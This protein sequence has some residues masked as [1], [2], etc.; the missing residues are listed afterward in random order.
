M[1][2]IKTKLWILLGVVALVMILS[3]AVM[4]MK[5][6]NVVF[7]LTDTEAIKNA[8]YLAEIVDFYCDGLENIVG[9]VRPGVQAMFQEDG[10]ADK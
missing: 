3:T 1:M 7:G 10:T 5:T 6:S 8:D 2:K 4:Y 9:N